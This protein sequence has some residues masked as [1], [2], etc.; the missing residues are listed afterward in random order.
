RRS[1]REG[2]LAAALPPR[3]DEIA[4]DRDQPDLQEEPQDRGKAAEAAGQA[5]AEEKP[6]QARAEEAGGEP[7]EEARAVEEAAGRRRRGASRA[8]AGLRSGLRHAALDRT[9]RGWRGLRHRRGVEGP[10][11]AAAEA[12][13]RARVNVGRD[14]DERSRKR[15]KH[16]QRTKAKETHQHSPTEPAFTCACT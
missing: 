9:R 3:P 12:A 5:V 2:R 10:G 8:R 15:A 1:A 13:A 4:D 7:A 11:A 6:D 14:H 16:K